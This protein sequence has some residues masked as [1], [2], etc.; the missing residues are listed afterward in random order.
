M[1][2]GEVAYREGRTTEAFALLR[3]AVALEEQLS[4]DEPPGWMQPVRHALGA[5]L[6]AEGQHAEAEDVYRADLQRHP[7]NAWSLLGLKQSLE[8]QG[9]AAEVAAMEPAVREAWARADVSPAASCYCHPGARG[10]TANLL[11]AR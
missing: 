8:G 11:K 3:D 5:L 2:E 6:L 9:R 7:R 1:A 4:Y 10:E